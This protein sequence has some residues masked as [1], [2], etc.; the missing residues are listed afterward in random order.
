MACSQDFIQYIIDQCSGAGE[1]AAK[2]MMGDWC[3]YCNGTLFALACDNNLYIKV[4]DAAKPLLKEMIL[5]P[6]YEGAKDC[7]HITDIDD[8][9]YLERLIRATLP[10]L[11]VPKKKR[12]PMKG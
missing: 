5:R 10:C 9:D 12:N 8:R 2:K 7:F 3:L 4:T 11:P 6:P 1:I